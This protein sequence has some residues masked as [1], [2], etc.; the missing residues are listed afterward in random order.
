MGENTD[1]NDL[2]G[3]G[4]ENPFSM[5]QATAFMDDGTQLYQEQNFV[6]ASDVFSRAYEILAHHYGDRDPRCAEVLYRYGLALFRCAV[7]R[8]AVMGDDR[9]GDVAAESGKQLHD[10]IAASNKLA[11]HFAFEGDGDYGGDAPAAAAASSSAPEPPAENEETGEDNVDDFQ[12][13]WEIL[14]LARIVLTQQKEQL[15]SKPDAD[16]AEYA[17]VVR[18]LS[19]TFLTL[20][21]I[22][23]EQEQ[24]EN[25]IRDFTSALSTKQATI[26]S[27]PA[28]DLAEIH[29]KLALALELAGRIDDAIVSVQASADVLNQRA[30]MLRSEL[31]DLERAALGSKGKKEA[32][33]GAK[34]P[35]TEMEE[36]RR[37]I[38]EIVKEIFPEILAKA[39]ELSTFSETQAK[40]KALAAGDP[41]SRPN[42]APDAPVQDVS[43]LVRKSKKAVDESDDAQ[44]KSGGPSNGEM[45]VKRKTDDEVEPPSKK[46]KADVEE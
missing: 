19:V 14:D 4:E 21:D 13:A 17:E 32:V 1:T 41:L 27:T 18:R 38:D 36:R 26:T 25:A 7:E 8:T 39:E 11:S 35:E 9:V 31:V 28:R 30:D 46:V 42:A 37:E 40:A 6:A 10:A 2:E 43:N 12:L 34:D 3:D 45:G 20:G 29:F 24:W 23:L 33:A 22:M 15:E 16:K 44:R 5:E